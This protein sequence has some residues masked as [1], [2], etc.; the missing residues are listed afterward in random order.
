MFQNYNINVKKIYKGWNMVLR[1][2][3]LTEKFYNLYDVVMVAIKLL[4]SEKRSWLANAS[5]DLNKNIK[6]LDHH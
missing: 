1:I 3:N 4:N 6:K 5:L 2:S